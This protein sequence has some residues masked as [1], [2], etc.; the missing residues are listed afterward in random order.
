MTQKMIIT[1]EAKGEEGIKTVATS[2]NHTMVMDEPAHLGGQD[3]GPN[4]LQMLLGSLAGCENVIGHFVAKEMNMTLNSL[5]F[6]IKGTLD[7]RGFQGVE[8]VKPQFETVEVNVTVDTDEDET[9]ERIQELK[10]QTDARCPV[11][12]TLAAAGIELQTSWTKA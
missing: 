4:P 9:N 10:E 11:Y 3:A 7:P 2:S 5:A 6:D 1:A 12:Q 8:G